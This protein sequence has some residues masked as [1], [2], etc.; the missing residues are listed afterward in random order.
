MAP[1]N[2]VKEAFGCVFD[3]PKAFCFLAAGSIINNWEVADVQYRSWSTFLRQFGSRSRGANRSR[4]R[5]RIRAQ[6]GSTFGPAESVL[7]DDGMDRVPDDHHGSDDRFCAGAR[8]G[9]PARACR[10]DHR[11][12]HHVRL[13]RRAGRARHQEGNELRAHRQ[14]RLRPQR[15]R[16]FVRPAVHPSARLVRGADGHHRQSQSVRHTT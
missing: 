3:A 15:L 2:T 16:V 8:D 7:G 13:C 11:Q 1:K 10:H 9:F 5:R 6:T 4:P 12:Y 14:H